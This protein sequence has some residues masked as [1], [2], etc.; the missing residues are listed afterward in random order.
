LDCADCDC[1]NDGVLSYDGDVGLH[2]GAGVEQLVV[3]RFL[4]RRW[5]A[6]VELFFQQRLL[7]QRILVQQL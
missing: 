6:A 7:L 3:Q 4:F 5:N 2:D 1:D